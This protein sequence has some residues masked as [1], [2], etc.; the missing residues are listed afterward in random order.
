MNKVPLHSRS[1]V[2]GVL[3][4]IVTKERTALFRW[5]FALFLFAVAL[6]LRLGLDDE[7]PAGFPYLTFFPSVIITTLVSGLWPG[8][9]SAILGGL[10]SWYFFISPVNTFE[11]TPGALLAL[12]FYAFIVAVDILIIHTISV[13]ARTL[14]AERQM[15]ALLAASKEKENAEL[16][17]MDAFRRSIALELNH[18]MKNQLALVQAIVNQTVRT[19]PDVESVS[20][21]LVA[22][23]ACLAQAHD[24]IVE[25]AGGHTT[26]DAIIKKTLAVYDDTRLHIIGPR[27]ELAERSS[28]SLSLIIHELGT[29]AAKYGALS[30]SS[31]TISINWELVSDS[32]VLELVWRESGGP[33]VSQPNRRGAGSRL[34]SAGIGAGSSSSIL[35]LQ[36]GLEFHLSAPVATLREGAR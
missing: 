15:L 26:V 31:G 5:F 8:I 2:I 24:M 29:N 6:C 25:G 27:V 32:T 23:L 20:T 10:S 11:L 33:L 19:A 17:E 16:I 21:N 1:T 14:R 13:T 34:M 30:T 4:T 36:S 12:A 35:Y 18:R 28:L 3:Q 9:V 7:L 22:R